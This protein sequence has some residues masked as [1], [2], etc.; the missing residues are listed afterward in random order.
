MNELRILVCGGRKY[1]MVW[2]WALS[3]WIVDEDERNEFDRILETACIQGIK[4]GDKVGIIHGNAKGA[5]THAS[6]FVRDRRWTSPL[7][8]G[9]VFEIPYPADWGRYK[10]AAGHIRNR[11]MLIDGAPDIVLSFPGGSG[12]ANMVKIS[13]EAG[14]DVYEMRK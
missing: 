13:R 4:R 12:T 3:G 2:D 10:K 11:E 1:A 7:L 14:I 9:K 5:D 8:H 6:T